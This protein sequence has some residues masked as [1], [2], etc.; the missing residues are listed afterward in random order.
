MRRGASESFSSKRGV[1]ISAEKYPTNYLT[2][3][4]PP[5]GRL[6]QIGIPLFLVLLCLFL[7]LTF[8]VGIGINDDMGYIHHARAL[9]G[10]DNIIADG[11]SQ[12]AFRLGMVVPLTFACAVFG[13][14]EPAFSTYPIL[15][16]L[17]TCLFIYLTAHVLWGERSAVLSAILWIIY[18]LQIV[19]DTQLSPSNQHA[20]CIAGALFF[21]FAAAQGSKKGLL[22]KWQSR[23]LFMTSGAFLGAGWMV[24]ELFV[25]MGIIALPLIIILRPRPA[26]MVWIFLGCARVIFRN[27]LIAKY[28]SGSWFARIS[29]IISTEQVVS[30][31]KES[32]YL[33]RVLFRIFDANPFH[34][35]AHF[36]VLWYF[37]MFFTFLAL[38]QRQWIAFGFAASAWLVLGYLQW[39]VMSLEGSPIA[40]YI[41]YLSMI[42]PLKCLAIGGVLGHLILKSGRWNRGVYFLFGIFCL[43][44]AFSGAQA[45]VSA[46]IPTHDFRKIANFF[47]NHQEKNPVYMDDISAQFV[48]LFSRNKL[49]I[50][51]I[52]SLEGENPPQTGWLVTNGSRGIVENREYRNAMPLWY[53]SVPKNWELV[54]V[55][56]G[57]E[58]TE[59]FG[60][61]D[62]K[63]YRIKKRLPLDIGNTGSSKHTP[64]LKGGE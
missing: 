47:M 38:F 3:L 14:N 24:N 29:S 33:P 45:T 42:V 1:H 23:I 49:K 7:R 5:E 54:K 55:V 64:L 17:L 6:R 12:L 8:F 58:N 30:S 57:N 19:F 10:G 39:G 40:K 35:E 44:L 51:R 20:T 25:I 4:F 34:D 21:F 28:A 31:N 53:R 15:C 61:F 60:N 63:I 50:E 36:G 37:F 18:P 11:G 48:A 62:P 43:H 52:E 41:R 22:R 13:Y 32:E 2:Q 46:K 27:I 9:S 59:V 16:S 26:D 56:K